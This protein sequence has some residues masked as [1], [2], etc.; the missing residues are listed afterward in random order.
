MARSR[1]ELH[2]KLCDILGSG[3]C[4]F[5][6]PASFE[7]CYPC[8]V[9]RLLRIDHQYADNKRYLNHVGYNVTVI[10]EDPDSDIPDKLIESDL[11]CR[12]DRSY[13]ADGLNHFVFTVYF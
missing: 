3:N 6:P 2:A 4:Y 10:T 9:Y 7:M 12:F 8:M 5:N 13:I 1:E 11:I